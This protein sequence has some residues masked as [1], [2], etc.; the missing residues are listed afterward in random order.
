MAEKAEISED[1]ERDAR[2]VLVSGTR[3]GFREMALEKLISSLKN[4]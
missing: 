1:G 3:G 4:W 2:G